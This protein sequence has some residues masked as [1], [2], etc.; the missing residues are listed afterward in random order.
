[1][2]ITKRTN[3]PNVVHNLVRHNFGDSLRWNFVKNN[4]RELGY[5]ANDCAEV[6]HNMLQGGDDGEPSFLIRGMY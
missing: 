2:W 3:R 4:L 6:A 5:E 1:M